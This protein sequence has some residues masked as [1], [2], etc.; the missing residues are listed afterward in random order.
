MNQFTHVSHGPVC[1]GRG[2]AKRSLRSLPLSA[3][4][5]SSA[6]SFPR[7]CAYERNIQWGMLGNDHLGDC[8]IAA[9]LHDILAKGAVAQSASLPT[10]QDQDAINLYSSITGYNPADPSTDQGTVMLDAMNYVK[11]NGVF[12][13]PVEGF[14]TLDVGNPDQLRAALYIFGGIQLGFQVPD[15]IMTVASGGSWSMRPGNNTA[16]D[17]GHAIY[18]VGYGHT[19]FRLVSWGTTYT[20]NDQFLADYADEAYCIVSSEWI[21]ASGVSPTGL[22]LAGLLADLQ[23]V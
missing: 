5:K 23:T 17:G 19:G 1:L 18:L 12:Q 20:F 16:I 10:F 11:K 14:A 3:Y 7:V 8:V 9:M 2:A 22:D 4:M 15:Y 13:F 21:K 6:V